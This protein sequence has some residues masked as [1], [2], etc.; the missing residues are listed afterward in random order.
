MAEA[1]EVQI[2]IRRPSREPQLRNRLA[3]LPDGGASR[4]TRIMLA[5]PS[6]GLATTLIEGGAK[7]H[8]VPINGAQHTE[9]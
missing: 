1:S 3:T 4:S 8:K 5:L 7:S 2:T 6:A 9:C